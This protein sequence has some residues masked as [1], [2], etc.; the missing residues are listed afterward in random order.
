MRKSALRNSE[1]G[2]PLAGFGRLISV[3]TVC[4]NA[5]KTIE[6]TLQSVV[7]QEDVGGLVEHIVVD[8]AS[9]DDTLK[10]L[11]QFANARWTSEPDDGI[12][13]AFNKGSHLATG[14]YILYLN[15][16]DYLYDQN[17]LHDVQRFIETN[18]HPDWI[19]G[20]FADSSDGKI[21]ILPKRY[22]PSCWSLMFR[23]RIGHPAVFLKRRVLIE[24]GGFDTHFKMAMDYDLW[25]RLCSRG[26]KPV[27]FQRIV[28]VFSREGLTS[29][30]SPTLIQEKQEVERRFRDNPVKRLVGYVYDRQKGRY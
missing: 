26:Y 11:K 13:D 18:Q 1:T 9:E 15:A 6:A 2:E 23:N 7:T 12:S 22:P 29:N 30:I 4:R 20:D 19:V 28:S 21:A 27:Y 10:I 17:V 5:E 3:V 8:G 24:M 25:Q 14:E 16:D